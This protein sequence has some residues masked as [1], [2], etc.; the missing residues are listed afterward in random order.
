MG[1]PCPIRMDD[2]V[3]MT[4]S[5]AASSL[6]IRLHGEPAVLLQDGA[7][8]LLERRAAALL[9]LAALSPGISRMRAAT[10]LWPDSGDPRR[11]LRQQL[12]RFRQVF[13]RD[14]LTGRDS[15]GLVPDVVP[16]VDLPQGGAALLCGFDFDDCEGF[17]SWLSQQRLLLRQNR[18]GAGAAEA[19]RSRGGGRSGRRAGGRA[20]AAGA[21]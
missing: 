3:D 8:I 16:V 11:N 14:L 19:G 18:C 1:L 6:Q 17:A 13:G 5:R 20:S 2:D 10:L 4:A 15:L 9:A 7:V 21:G 12:L